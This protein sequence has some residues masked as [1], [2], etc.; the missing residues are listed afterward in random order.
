[1]KENAPNVRVDARAKGLPDSVIGI[2]VDMGLKLRITTK[3]WM[4][5]MGMPFH[6]T[7]IN[8]ENQFDR[9]HSYADLLRYPQRYKMHW[10][11]WNGGTARVL[12]WG[13]PRFA[14][15]FAGSTHLYDGDGFEVNEPLATKM[16][17]Q[18]H[19]MK[20]F[21]LLN[22]KYRYY[23]YEFERYWHFFQSF[24]RMGYDPHT[25]PE[26]WQ[27]E[28]QRRFG[29]SAAPHVEAGLHRASWI[30][31]RI[32]AACYPY[33]YFPMTRGWAE[34]QRL[35]DLPAYAKAQGSDTQQFASF[36][37]EAGNLIDG[38]ETAKTRPGQTSRWFAEAAE[39]VLLQV[40]QAQKLVGNDRNKEFDS[41]VTDL[42]I[43]ANLAI[44]HSRRI[45]AAVNYRLFER[46][47]DPKALDAAISYERN[48]IEAWRRLVA[49]A[50][51][52]YA[53]D[54][55]MGVRGANLCGHWRDEL[56]ALD[57]GLRALEQQRQEL[58]PPVASKPAPQYTALPGPGD[59][60]PPVVVHRPVTT[61]QA[62]KPLTVAAEVRDPSGV[63][64]VR[65]RYRSVNQHQDYQMLP[66]LATGQK[67]LYQAVIPAE[68]V[69]PAWDLMYLIEVMDSQ[70]N[71]AIYPDLNK[72]TPYVIV[73]LTR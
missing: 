71:G 28:F 21:E 1:M 15:R 61:A 47:G 34:K 29:K 23:D 43:L 11:L 16:E 31:P 41:T 62:G 14:S 46:T 63:K 38:G 5:Q 65:L 58:R 44:F 17:A 8:R 37:E 68:H 13:D 51:D 27:R 6:P 55:K 9:R 33:G 64:W 30:L 54:L 26:V 57:K 56:A 39:E 36:D 40:A 20:P 2:G 12:L 25:P 73:R 72:E 22:P 10:R 24:G 59:H 48:A 18:P 4:E 70:G 53:D 69:V 7:H 3:Y 49:E 50:G 45:P 52:V 60:E 42:K 67:D 66:M 19:D 32:V 35:G